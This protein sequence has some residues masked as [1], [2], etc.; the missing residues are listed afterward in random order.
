MEKTIVPVADT[1]G[2]YAIGCEAFEVVVDIVQSGGGDGDFVR[3]G[4]VEAEDG[5]DAGAPADGVPVI[6]EDHPEFGR[7]LALGGGD[8]GIDNAVYDSLCDPAS[9]RGRESVA[10]NSEDIGEPG[11]GHGRAQINREALT[12][13]GRVIGVMGR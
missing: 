4:N 2:G 5:A 11:G 13:E 10:K 12:E 1:F 6:G 7:P 8:H 3:S 9:P